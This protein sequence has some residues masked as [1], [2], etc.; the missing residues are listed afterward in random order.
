VISTE[1]NL[2]DTCRWQGTKCNATFK[3]GKNWRNIV[4][5]SGYEEREYGGR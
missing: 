3:H 1:K 5:C 2:C 4:E